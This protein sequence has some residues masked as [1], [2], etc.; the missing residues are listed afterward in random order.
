MVVR[1]AGTGGNAAV[2]AASHGASVRLY[3]RVGDDMMGKLVCEELRTRGV[4]LA[5][6]VDPSAR[7]GAML[8]VVDGDERSMVADRGANGRFDPS[9]LPDR[10]V[11]GAVLVSG[12]LLLAQRSH[13][14]ARAA[15]DRADAAHV[16]VDAASWP[17]LEA[18]GPGRFFEATRSASLILAN[19][20]EAEIL[21]GANG[22]R[23]MMA[24]GDRY[25]MAVIKLGDAGAVLSRDGRLTEAS[26]RPVRAVDPTGAGD[27]FDGALMA[28][29]AGGMEPEEAMNVACVAG[30]TA[31]QSEDLWPA[32]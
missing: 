32:V 12:Y 23:A 14:G 2:W 29:L 30:A 8:V 18:F 17:L 9:D 16:A 3:G 22:E 7:T 31:A 19:L 27:A 25:P 26:V 6:S 5:V 15:L 4:D 20:Q 11:A 24:L 13:P 21:A 28:A 1:P 10:L